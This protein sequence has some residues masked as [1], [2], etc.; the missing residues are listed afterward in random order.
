MATLREC[1]YPEIWLS[2]YEGHFRVSAHF[3]PIV[4]VPSDFRCLT[5]KGETIPVCVSPLYK[6]IHEAKGRAAALQEELQN[7]GCKVLFFFE[8]RPPVI[9]NPHETS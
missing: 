3:P 5:P 8:L 4:E 7:Q 6:T 1:K 9:G 2:T